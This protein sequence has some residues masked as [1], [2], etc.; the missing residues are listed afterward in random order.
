MKAASSSHGTISRDNFILTKN[1]G[2]GEG[3]NFLL[4][5]EENKELFEEIFSNSKNFAIEISAAASINDIATLWDTFK[6]SGNYGVVF[7]IILLDKLLSNKDLDVKDYNLV[8]IDY[9]SNAGNGILS[10]LYSYKL[11]IDER[12]NTTKY[13]PRESLISSHQEKPNKFIEL[14]KNSKE[15]GFSKVKIINDVYQRFRDNEAGNQQ[16]DKFKAALKKAKENVMT[17]I[18]EYAV[19][20][21]SNKEKTAFDILEDYYNKILSSL[22]ILMK[23]TKKT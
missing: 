21:Y 7:I 4:D 16:W 11:K 15:I 14:A 17:I 1:L 9:L 18:K 6:N 13:S 19:N 10:Q 8:F 23:S 20:F 12:N 22:E 3:I 5:N 2:K